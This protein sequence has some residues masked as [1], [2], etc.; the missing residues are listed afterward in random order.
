[1][2]LD[3]SGRIIYNARDWMDEVVDV[4]LCSELYT[5]AILT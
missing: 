4:M 2:L 5:S 1:M 3:S